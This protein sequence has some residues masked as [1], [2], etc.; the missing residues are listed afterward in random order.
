[1]SSLPQIRKDLKA[2]LAAERDPQR[3]AEIGRAVAAIERAE[4]KKLDS[5][6][7]SC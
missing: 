2:A 7:Q 5:A 3:R 6:K 1:M 4:S